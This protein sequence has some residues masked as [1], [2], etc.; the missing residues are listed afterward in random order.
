MGSN[1]NF[2]YIK[3]DMRLIQ[4]GFKFYRSTRVNMKK[5][6]TN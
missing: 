5:I 3:S 2:Y 1:L 4:S 6:I